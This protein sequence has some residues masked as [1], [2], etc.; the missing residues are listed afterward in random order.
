MTKKQPPT[1]LPLYKLPLYASTV[2]GLLDDTQQSHA[3]FLKAK[4][5]PWTLDDT[6]VD[7]TIRLYTER[8]ELLALDAEQLTRW[9][10]EKLTQKEERTINRLSEQVAQ[11]RKLTSEILEIVREI[12][13]N[14]IDRILAR[15]PADLAIDV[16]TGK[17]KMPK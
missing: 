17:L 6:T 4:D 11:T 2:E 3:L 16:L 12:K 13:E 15:D 1:W 9:K 5:K 14:T 8:L 10:R 7:R